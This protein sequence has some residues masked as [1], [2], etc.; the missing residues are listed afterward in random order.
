M[1]SVSFEDSVFIIN[2]R[3]R[4]IRDTLC[5]NPPHELFLEKT[6]DDL[7]FVDRILAVLSQSLKDS[8][9]QN[10]GNGEFDYLIDA[11]WQFSQLLIEFTRD[12]NLPEGQESSE[13]KDK[14]SALKN[15][16]DLRRKVLDKTFQSVEQVNTEPV[17]SSSELSG[18]FGGN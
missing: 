16:S 17:V 14:I 5:L 9:N 13:I 6:I 1:N 12:A 4:A 8:K 10:N 15:N 3:L 18:L 11:E 7:V 2:I